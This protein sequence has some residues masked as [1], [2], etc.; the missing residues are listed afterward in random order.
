[1][2]RPWGRGMLGRRGL[3]PVWL[4]QIVA[5]RGCDISS[6]GFRLY[7]MNKGHDERFKIRD[8]T[9]RFPF[10]EDFLVDVKRIDPMSWVYISVYSFI[11]SL[12]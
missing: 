1:M 9:I 2:Q 5:A 7:Q 3:R 6:A 4:E 12:N 8:D 11:H 10:G